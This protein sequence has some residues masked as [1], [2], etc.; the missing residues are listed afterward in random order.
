MKLNYKIKNVYQI[1]DICPGQTFE[2]LGDPY[3]VVK[4]DDIP[5]KKYTGFCP[6]VNFRTNQLVMFSPITHVS[7]INA[8]LFVNENESNEVFS[9]KEDGND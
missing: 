3:L 6:A 1:M 9:D 5:D 4:V 8:E 7:I 2:Y